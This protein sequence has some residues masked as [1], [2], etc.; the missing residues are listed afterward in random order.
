MG[1]GALVIMDDS[2][3]LVNV[4]MRLV[5]FYRHESC[6]K[7][8]PCREGTYFESELMHRLEAGIAS[9]AELANLADICANMDGRCFCPLGDTAT[10]FVMSAYRMFPEE[11]ESHCG[12][13]SC[14]VRESVAVAV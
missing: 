2:T 12:A 6:G 10:W 13:G 9:R 14:P 4:A 7:C 11:F 5:D 8:V 3:C 1:A